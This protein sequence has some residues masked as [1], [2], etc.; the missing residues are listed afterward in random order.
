MN[1]TN[2]VFG[3]LVLALGILLIVGTGCSTTSI[4]SPTFTSSVMN[5]P[6]NHTTDAC[7]TIDQPAPVKKV[8][9]LPTCSL[10]AGDSLGMKLIANHPVMVAQ[11]REAFNLAHNRSIASY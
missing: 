11:R 9:T 1:T 4:V 8:Y 3:G 5:S 10:A 7:S 2:R 6:G